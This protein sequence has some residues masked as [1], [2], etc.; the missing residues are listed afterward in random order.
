[1]LAGGT[2]SLVPAGLEQCGKSAA[3]RRQRLLS[4]LRQATGLN[5]SEGWQD[6]P[7]AWFDYPEPVDGLHR[8]VLEDHGDA[9]ELRV[10]LAELTPQAR[11][12]YGDPVRVERLAALAGEDAWL[13][14]PNPHVAF[15]Q[16]SER[17]RWYTKCLLTPDVYMRQWI[18]DLAKAGRTINRADL[19][20]GT[21]LH[22][23]ITR[24]YAQP[25]DDAGLQRLI[26]AEPTRKKFDMRP[27]IRVSRRWTW[28]E[29]CDLDGDRALAPQVHDALGRVLAILD[30]PAL[31]RTS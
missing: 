30:Q 26:E 23:L 6:H 5:V 4:V 17:Q 9:I 21:L 16:S 13:L 29:A 12:L 20:D 25:A 15:W 28:Q 7:T 14:V 22:W 19:A 2:F 31:V 10:W 1:M 24:G 8:A 3:R 11:C 27:S 18:D